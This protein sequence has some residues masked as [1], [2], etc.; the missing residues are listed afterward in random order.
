MVAYTVAQIHSRCD[1][2]KGATCDLCFSDSCHC[3]CL[4]LSLP[5]PSRCCC[6]NIAPYHLSMLL[7]KVQCCC[8]GSQCF[9]SVAGLSLPNHPSC[10][11][12]MLQPHHRL[13]W[14]QPIYFSCPQILFHGAQIC[15]Y[16]YSHGQCGTRQPKWR[17]RQPSFVNQK[18]HKQ[19][20]DG[21]QW[22]Q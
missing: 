19:P 21:K 17:I 16:C 11:P 5:T 4:D 3:S 9:C 1:S 13:M 7:R 2:K 20:L 6:F 12:F 18:T 14:P 22:L 10:Q 8:I 15:E